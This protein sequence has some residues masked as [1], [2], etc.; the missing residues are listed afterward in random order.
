MIVEFL[1]EA[2]S[3]L[4]HAI[5]YYEGQLDAVWASASG[6]KSISTSIGSLKILKSHNCAAAAIDG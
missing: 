6:T 5:E 1:P 4:L 3:E 2:K